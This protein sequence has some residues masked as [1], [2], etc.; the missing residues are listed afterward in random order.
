MVD[1]LDGTKEYIARNDEF[2]VNIA[3]LEWDQPVAGVV[4]MPV[5]GRVFWAVKGI[6]AW[7]DEGFQDEPQTWRQIHVSSRTSDLVLAV[8]RSHPS[9]KTERLMCH[10]RVAR[11]VVAGSSL[12]GCLIACGEADIYFRF[13]RTMEWDTAAMQIIVEEA[14]GLMRQPDGSA[15]HYNKTIPDN[16]NG[17]VVMNRLENL[18]WREKRNQFH[19]LRIFQPQ[20]AGMY[21]HFHPRF[22]GQFTVDVDGKRLRAFKQQSGEGIEANLLH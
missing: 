4:M 12:K 6:G 1:P 16:P 21:S 14:G 2:S 9:A 10:P 3:L 11:T 22:L 15:I 13:G 5:G 8:S 7:M 17:F 20:C 19:S 18:D